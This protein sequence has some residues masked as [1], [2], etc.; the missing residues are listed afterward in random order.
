MFA[1][2]EDGNR[3]IR[4]E[5]GDTVRVDFRGDA[6]PGAAVSFDRVLLANAGADSVVGR[7]LI[8][9][10]TVDAEI[11]DPLTKGKKLEVQKFRRRKNSR[12]FTGHRQKYTQVRITGINVPGLDKAASASA[13]E[14]D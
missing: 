6:E 5:E 1:I 2:I 4:V 14:A 11:V 3:Q 13:A 12:T 7:P 9:G 8:D 10:A